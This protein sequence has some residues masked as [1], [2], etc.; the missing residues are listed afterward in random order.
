[1]RDAAVTLVR[2][3]GAA[4]SE[5]GLAINIGKRPRQALRTDG[6]WKLEL[7]II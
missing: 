2:R 3:C 7:I 4:K 5:G 1:M 6:P